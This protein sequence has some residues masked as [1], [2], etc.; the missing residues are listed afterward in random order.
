MRNTPRHYRRGLQPWYRMGSTARNP[1]LTRP[2][3]G[4]GVSGI[5]YGAWQPMA[6]VHDF[7]IVGECQFSHPLALALPDSIAGDAANQNVRPELAR[8]IPQLQDY[9]LNP[10]ADLVLAIAGKPG[11][12]MIQLYSL[13]GG[14]VGRKLWEDHWNAQNETVMVRWSTGGEARA[15]AK[16]VGSGMTDPRIE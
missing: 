5:R 14:A 16:G 15:W 8:A 1:A 7:A 6:T 2:S 11:E 3:C 10:S 13:R 4:V 12:E 9:F